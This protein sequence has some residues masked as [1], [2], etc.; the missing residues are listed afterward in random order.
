MLTPSNKLFYAIEAVLFIAYNAKAAPVSGT[1]VSA[2]QNLP[3]RYLEPTMQKL[4]RAGILRGVRGPTGGY[5]LG[6]ERRRISLADICASV[7]EDTDLPETKTALGKK[8]LTPTA[9]T[10]I[11]QWQAQ[12][13]EVTLADLCER[14]SDANIATANETATDFTI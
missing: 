4:V 10:L 6:R 7:T 3:T 2:A 8:I 5:M 14:A 11:Q 13:A 1:Q 9:A 12:L